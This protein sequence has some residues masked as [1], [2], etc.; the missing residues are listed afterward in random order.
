MADD[1]EEEVFWQV[2]ENERFI[3][4][5][6]NRRPHLRHSTKDRRKVKGRGRAL[7]PVEKVLLSSFYGKGKGKG[8]FQW[9]DGKQNID[10]AKSKVKAKTKARGKLNPVPREASPS[11]LKAL[12]HSMKLLMPQPSFH[13][14]VE[15]VHRGKLVAVGVWKCVSCHAHDKQTQEEA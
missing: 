6:F 11:R 13:T 2:D 9:K 7:S 12:L 10:F 1:D 15:L 8:Q 5:R 4:Q 14:A 3:A